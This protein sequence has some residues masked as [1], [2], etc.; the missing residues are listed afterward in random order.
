MLIFHVITQGADTVELDRVAV[1]HQVI[2]S[3]FQ[4]RCEPEHRQFG[5]FG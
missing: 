2:G 3:I 4:F 5:R 1:G